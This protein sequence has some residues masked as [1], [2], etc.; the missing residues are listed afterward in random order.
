M[1]T[2][3]ADAFRVQALACIRKGDNLKAEHLTSGFKLHHYH[4]VL[5][6]ASTQPFSYNLPLARIVGCVVR[7][8]LAHFFFWAKGGTD[9]SLWKFIERGGH[10][11]KAVPQ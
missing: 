8:V 3:G 2:V 10:R 6:L 11:L 7:W 1:R 5:P 4:V 9:F